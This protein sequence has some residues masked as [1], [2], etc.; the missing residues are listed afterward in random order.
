MMIKKTITLLLLLFG[1]IFSTHAQQMADEKISVEVENPAYDGNGPLILI[2]GGH[3]NFHQVD[4][5]FAPFARL[6]RADG[7]R[8]DSIITFDMASLKIADVLVI[9]NPLHESNIGN[10]QNPCPSAFTKKEIKNVKKWVKKGGNLLLIAD[11]MPFG[12]AAQE[13]GRAFGFEFEN[14]FAMA[15][16]RSWP[17]ETFEKEEGTLKNHKLTEGISEL[18]AFTGSAVKA[19]ENAE[20][21]TRF[22][23]GHILLLSDVAWRFDE[24]T[25]QKSLDEYVQGAI[26]EVGK[27]RIAVFSEAAMFTA[28]VVNNNNG[29]VTKVGF[30]APEAPNNQQ[31]I[32]NLMHW[33]DGK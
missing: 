22:P 6:M 7:Y 15:T 1:L 12:G 33:L 5:R 14:G 2:D 24:K 31:F 20:V 21:L 32:L 16:K 18:A 30:N 10:W 13:L 19:P 11:H 28:Q 26:M 29:G 17:P 3:Y 9:A 8:V 27:G 25:P 4:G 23:E